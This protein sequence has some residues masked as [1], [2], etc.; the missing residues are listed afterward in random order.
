MYTVV[1]I[2]CSMHNF[3]YCHFAISCD[4]VTGYSPKVAIYSMNRDVVGEE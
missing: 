4:D 1:V 2:Y 3:T